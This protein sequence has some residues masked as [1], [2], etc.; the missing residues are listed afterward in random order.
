M[1]HVLTIPI[2]YIFPLQLLTRTYDT[3]SH[4][5]TQVSCE[6]PMGKTSLHEPVAGPG[7]FMRT[8]VDLGPKVRTYCIYFP[9]T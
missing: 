7:A 1:T 5:R 3:N 4:V 2:S 9:R 8:D 6:G